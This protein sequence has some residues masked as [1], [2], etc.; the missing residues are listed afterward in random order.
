MHNKKAEGLMN[1]VGSITYN[2]TNDYM[3]RYILQKNKKVLI[4][5]ICSLLHLQ[6][7]QIKT[8]EIKNPINLAGSV[9]GKDFV[10]DIHIELN[11]NT[12]INLEMQ[13][14]NKHNWP[15]RSLSYLCRRYDQLYQGQEYEEAL[16]VY[17]IGFLDYTLFPDTPEFYA[18]YKMQNVKNHYTYSD[19]FVLSV[20]DLSS[21]ELATEEDEACGL[22]YW[23][24]LFKAKTWE[25]LKMLA[26]E[27]E[28]LQEAA[29]SIYIANADDIVRQQCRAR[30]EAERYERTMKRDMQILKEENEQLK[31]DNGQLRADISELKSNM[32]IL[33][34][35]L[36]ER[37]KKD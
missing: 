4:G 2:M 9:S 12:Y 21:I 14:V 26:K 34:Q 7:S 5:L 22:V 27:N 29:E 19:K 3:F 24:R 17:H 13:V 6:P 33:M 8:I 18:T 15:D 30:E 10:L 1:A 37:D 36:Q 20:V 25:E 35:K 31:E 32:A 23:A 11:N 16:P 28:Y